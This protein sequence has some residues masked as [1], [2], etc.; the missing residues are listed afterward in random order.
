LP[1][2]ITAID[3]SYG[4][5]LGGT[6]IHIT[7]T[8]FSTATDVSFGGFGISE[9]DF[10]ITGD[11]DI[12]LNS[13]A[14]PGLTDASATVDIQINT[15]VGTSDI[16]PN[17]QFTY[18][19]PPAITAID[20]SYGS[21]LGGTHI[22]ITGTGFSTATDVSFGGFDLTDFTITGDT[23]ISLNS[24]ALPGLTDASA[25]VDIQIL[26][27]VGTSDI[28]PNDQFTYYLPPAITAIDVSYGSSLG[29]THIHITGTG[30]S[31]VTDVS[32]GGFGISE[33]D[34]TITGDT[35]IS[36]N[37][38][39]LPGLTDASAT[40]DI[41]INTRVGT[42]DI[43]PN[44]QFTY[45]LPP[46]IT[47]IDVSYGSSLGGTHIHITG[48]GFSTATDV[49]FGGFDLTNFTITGDTDI[50]LNSPALPGLTDASATVDIQINTRVG[51]SDITPNDQF[52]YYLPPAITA[53]DVSYGSYLGGTHIHITGTGFSTATDVS[54]GSVNLVGS[55]FTIT[56][57][58]DISLNSPPLLGLT[59]ESATVDIQINTRVGT[60]VITPNDQFTYYSH[61]PDITLVDPSFGYSSLETPITITGTGFSTATGI[62]FGGVLVNRFIVIDDT[63]IT[64]NTP[65]L[66]GLTNASASVDIRIIS[67]R[68]TSAITP[69]D[70]YTYYLTPPLP[71]IYS[72]D[73]SFGYSTGGD[74]VTVKGAN[75]INVTDVSFGGITIA[76][77]VIDTSTITL[78]T[79]SYTLTDA[80]RAVD[81]Q[82]VTKYGNSAMTQNS[83]FI[84]RLAAPTITNFMASGININGGSV[85]GSTYVTVYG[86]NLSTV[87]VNSVTIGGKPPKSVHGISP[88]SFYFK[89]PP[90]LSGNAFIVVTTPAGTATS[91]TPFIY[92]PLITQITPS[93]GLLTGNNLVDIRGIGF[94]SIK[95]VYF[96]SNPAILF[97]YI[98]D[99]HVTAVA[100]PSVS[101]ATN[102]YVYTGNGTST[103]VSASRYIYSPYITV[104]TPNSGT[105][106]GETVVQIEGIGLS[107]VTNVY[108]GSNSATILSIS[109]TSITVISPKPT[110]N[111]HTVDVV[112]VDS[113]GQTQ[114]FSIDKYTYLNIPVIQGVLP[115]QGS[116]VG[117]AIVTI[118]G[119]D[120]T[121]VNRV[122]FG[123]IDASFVVIDDTKIN[124][125]SPVP[126][127]PGTV[128]VTA[129][130]PIGFSASTGNDQ[131][132]Y[133]LDSSFGLLPSV[134]SVSPNN[135]STIGGITVTIQGG[136]FTTSSDTAVFFGGLKATGVNVV[137][138]GVLQCIN[139]QGSLLNNGTPQ[140]VTVINSNGTSVNTTADVFNYYYGDNSYNYLHDLSYTGI[141]YAVY[142][143]GG[144]KIEQ[145]FPTIKLGSQVAINQYDV[146]NAVQIA[147]DVRIFNAKLGLI[148]DSRNDT[149][150]SSAYD[151]FNDS[152]PTDSITI[153]A[154]EFIGQLTESRV[155]SV[156]AYST[157]YRNFSQY[158][159]RYF[160]YPDG[161][162]SIFSNAYDISFNNNV[163]DANAFINIVTGK[164]VDSSGA[165]VNDLSGSITVFNINSILR[166]VVETNVFNNRNNY[167][168]GLADGFIE[169]DLIL[170]PAGTVVT[171]QLDIDP[172]LYGIITNGPNNVSQI[173]PQFNYVDGF[174]TSTTRATPTN[175]KHVLTAPILLIL[176]N[177]S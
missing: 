7:G 12:S 141:V 100:P 138:S 78:T 99:T 144:F 139:P 54:F 156:G 80:S 170:Y 111:E 109:D 134:T 164:T 104:I 148:K 32:F 66:P 83:K 115:N 15:R 53:I 177:L 87:N 123:S 10:T 33:T 149:I 86:T 57:D 30:F 136:N 40:V 25:T 50:S 108:F 22:H 49:S 35:D 171:L 118:T 146:T 97:N 155:M 5:S 112:A 113:T 69:N 122:L 26:T 159:N 162:S 81:I 52:T 63:A 166:T 6:H 72:I 62:S 143:V 93:F 41:Q 16:T 120:F 128:N 67:A 2:A 82:V 74:S 90:G 70:R 77:Q 38:P 21:S 131:F 34:F 37:S 18:Y 8:G 95:N 24:P 168:Y 135:G 151:A 158:V 152:F 145:G 124:T 160:S 114:Y 126:T 43:T 75:L 175:I 89:T 150:I 36:L 14:L 19:L 91:P 27:R 101:G 96:G 105:T 44:D 61:P 55:D 140:H 167:E 121:E 11:T 142:G 107:N 59:D 58:T 13:P 68:G 174:Y 154:N 103:D 161:F 137:T 84:Y 71:V 117:G 125:I 9:T 85:N 23:D 17:D 48:T 4:S 147:F 39:A 119:F 47:A 172:L 163:F 102:V 165:Y 76:C 98:N 132:T 46:A 79:P 176:T 65:S 88:Q 94:S 60:S 110:A 157:L 64:V 116:D 153:S 20:V 29:G 130:S 127:A 129:I 51:T 28:T 73:P 106:N 92:Y 169:G 133:I 173:D 45:Y 56:G 31:T 3:V 1:P 42:S